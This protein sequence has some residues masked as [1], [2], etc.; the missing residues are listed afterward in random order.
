[1]GYTD[2]DR[3]RDAQIA[4]L[5]REVDDCRQLAATTHN[6]WRAGLQAARRP[7]ARA[8]DVEAALTGADLPGGADPA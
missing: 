7:G 2:P 5:R 4:D 1:M 3:D 6:L 8:I